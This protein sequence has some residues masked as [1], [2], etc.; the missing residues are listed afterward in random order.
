MR[1]S[2]QGDFDGFCGLYSLVNAL[3]LVGYQR[4]RSAEHQRVFIALAEAV[5]A[6]KLRLA[7]GS[8]LGGR[9]LMRAAKSAFPAFRKA[10]GGRVEVSRPYRRVRFKTDAAFLTAAAE[11]MSRDDVALILYV[12]T[13]DRDHWTVAQAITPTAITL[14]DSV[15][16]KALPLNRYSTL[17][18]RYRIVVR[19][20]L[21]VRLRL[22]KR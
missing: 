18:G 6:A 13:P 5:P 22:R 15:A 11:A 7:V 19:E 4:P 17:K 3:D 21:M 8:G 16:M 1:P 2:R 9:D 12:S 20:T 14:R 10:L